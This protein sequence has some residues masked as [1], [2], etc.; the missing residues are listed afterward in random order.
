MLNLHKLKL[1]VNHVQSA[2]PGP[3]KFP[4][5]M[6]GRVDRARTTSAHFHNNFQADSER[7]DNSTH[8]VNLARNMVGISLRGTVKISVRCTNETPGPGTT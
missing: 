7:L 5:S 6:S 1:G 2:S 3:A 4:F 8:M